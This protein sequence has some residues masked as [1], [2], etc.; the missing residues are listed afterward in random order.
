MAVKSQRDAA[1]PPDLMPPGQS[2]RQERD[3]AGR[4]RWLWIALVSVL[5][6][7]LAVIFAL[8][9]LVQSPQQASVPAAAV[10]TPGAESRSAGK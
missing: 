1:A 4:Y 5:L 3:E 2:A 9:V 6:L 8:P 10:D 7:G